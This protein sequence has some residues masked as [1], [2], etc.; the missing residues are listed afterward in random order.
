[1]SLTT[2]GK[3]ERENAALVKVQLV[4]V[5]LGVVEH[6]HIATFHANSQPLTRRTVAQ[7]EDLRLGGGE[8]T[9]VECHSF[10]LE[11]SMK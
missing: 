7:G 8:Q 5:R 2:V 10:V 4:L 1:M 11:A 3:L 6:F 9:Q